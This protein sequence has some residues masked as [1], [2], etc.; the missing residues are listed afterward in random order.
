[1]PQFG[2]GNVDVRVPKSL[3]TLEIK[4]MVP[5][6]NHQNAIERTLEYPIE[7]PPLRV[8]AEGRKNACIVISDITRPVPNRIIL[9]PLLKALQ[10]S[11]I[12]QNN[13]T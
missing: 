1:M 13:I 8:L 3:P 6:P 9:P 5:L 7:T 11:G 2:K 4:P 10:K 12:K